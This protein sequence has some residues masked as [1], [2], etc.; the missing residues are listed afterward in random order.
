MV[1]GQLLPNLK[2][3]PNPN[4]NPNRGIFSLGIIV[5]FTP[6]PKTKPNLDSNL[7]P[8]RG[9]FFPGGNCSDTKKYV[10]GDIIGDII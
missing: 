4:P 3:N 2:T 10:T 9:Q 1:L 5:S 8:D 7:S 6:N